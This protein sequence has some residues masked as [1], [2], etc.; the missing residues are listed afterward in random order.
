MYKY[1]CAFLLS[2]CLFFLPCCRAENTNKSQFNA[3]LPRPFDDFFEETI[4]LE[5]KT[6]AEDGVWDTADI[7][8]SYID[9]NRKLIAFTFD[10]S[11]AKKLENI[12]AVFAEYNEHNPDC[13]ASATLFVN[14]GLVTE[15]SLTNLYAATA[16]GFE[17]GN[18]TQSHFDLTTLSNDVL[19][20]EI[21]ATDQILSRID[22]KPLHLL[23]AP[24]GLINA[25]V[26]AQASAPIINWTIDT[27]DWSGVSAEDIYNSI[28]HNLSSGAIVLMHDGYQNTVD[29]LKR[30][31]PDLKSNGYQVVGVSV[32]AKAHQCTLR[33]G[34]EYVR[35]RKQ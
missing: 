14:G 13:K 27:L 29:A 32:L 21:N 12:L 28:F 6:N 22:G 10:D 25:A 17:L 31:L 23:R 30:L 2:V 4:P 8:L 26:K 16:L 19:Q 11:P 34:S 3:Y 7:D 33:G 35:F 18:H 15:D 24:F 1:M 9:P 20:A 5:T